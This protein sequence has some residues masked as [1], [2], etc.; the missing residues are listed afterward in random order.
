MW[1]DLENR[2]NRE[3]RFSTSGKERATRSTSGGKWPRAPFF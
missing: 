1:L 2:L 3:F